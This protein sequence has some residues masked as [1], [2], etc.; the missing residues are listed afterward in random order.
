MSN[1]NYNTDVAIWK[2]DAERQTMLYLVDG[3][4]WVGGNRGYIAR[5]DNNEHAAKVLTEAGC[6]FT[7]KPPEDNKAVRRNNSNKERKALA[8]WRG[9]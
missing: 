7:V 5:F 8:K 4:V 3:F 2:T 9:R 1:Y 6:R